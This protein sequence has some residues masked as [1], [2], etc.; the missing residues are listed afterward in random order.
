[1]PSK[2]AMFVKPK[3]SKGKLGVEASLNEMAVTGLTAIALTAAIVILEVAE[4]AGPAGCSPSLKNF[5]LRVVSCGVVL[6]AIVR[7]VIGIANFDPVK[8]S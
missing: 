7:T 3:S 5:L 2:K 8:W 4:A 6:S 1:M